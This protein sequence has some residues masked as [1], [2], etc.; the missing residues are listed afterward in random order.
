METSKTVYF[1]QSALEGEPALFWQEFDDA[2]EIRA[3]ELCGSDAQKWTL[4]FASNGDVMIKNVASGK[5]V[6]SLDRGLPLSTADASSNI[7]TQKFRIQTNNGAVSFAFQS[8]DN[9][10]NADLEGGKLVAGKGIL[11]F[12]AKSST[13]QQWKFVVASK[14]IIPAGTEEGKATE[15]TV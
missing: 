6:T 11:S 9:G 8:R 1:I 4:E 12:P 5:Y 3:E 2:P 13:N 15:L 7:D 10:G 14:P